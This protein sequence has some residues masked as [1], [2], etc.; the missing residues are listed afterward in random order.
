MITEING[1]VIA[2]NI[3][4]TVVQRA[5]AVET[6][7][8]R[9]PSVAV[10]LVGEDKPSHLYVSL[11]QKAAHSV[12]VDFHVYRFQADESPAAVEEAVRFLASDA[13]VDAILIQLPLPEGFDTDALIEAMGHE[14]DVDGF[15]KE[16][17]AAFL[18]GTHSIP[19]VFPQALLT[20]AREATELDGRRAALI[21]NSP[22]FGEVLSAACTRAGMT[23]HLVPSEKLACLQAATMSADVIFVA[24]GTPGILTSKY[25][26]PNAV[27]IDGG[28]TVVDGRA[29]GDVDVESFRKEQKD[30]T[31]SPVP[32]GVGP[33][34]IAC[35]LA[36]VVTL[37]ERSLASSSPQD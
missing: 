25:V 21:V 14:K 27:I 7:R 32:G 33:V 31:V 24:C 2:E 23:P 9:R 19:P 3:L 26:K 30:V 36:N 10:V 18:R 29:V 4:D 6:A 8:G 13:D 17:R 5:R 12:G 34:T 11:K 37:A 22:M 20:M 16:S 28:I 15:H 1:T 35:L